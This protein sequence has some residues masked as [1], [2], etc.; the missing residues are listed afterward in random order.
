MR[1]AFC[2]LEQMHLHGDD[3][4]SRE[5]IIDERDVLASETAT[6]HRREDPHEM[7]RVTVPAPEGRVPGYEGAPRHGRGMK[8]RSP[9]LPALDEHGKP[10]LRSNYLCK[11]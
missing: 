11:G 9:G 8:T 3:L 7:I 1:G 4:L 6:V 2:T 10:G 5:K